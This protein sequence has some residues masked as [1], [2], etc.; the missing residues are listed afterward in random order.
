M[1]QMDN[2]VHQQSNYLL[3]HCGVNVLSLIRSVLI[4]FVR[5]RV[6][7]IN[8]N[9]QYQHLF[10]THLSLNMQFPLFRFKKN[11]SKTSCSQFNEI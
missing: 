5:F 1:L 9:F 6:T 8:I 4:D 11:Q 7:P 10:S 2:L 3:G